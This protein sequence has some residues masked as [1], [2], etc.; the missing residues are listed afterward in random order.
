MTSDTADTVQN[1]I[2]PASESEITADSGIRTRRDLILWLALLPVILGL[3]VLC[4][5]VAMLFN[6]GQSPANTQSL[7]RAS[8]TAWVYDLIP[9]INIPQLIED[10]QDDLRAE[11]IV[12]G[13]LPVVT[14]SFWVPP[15]PT[16]TATPPGGIST[17]TL[18]PLADTATAT[19]EAINT[20]APIST[21][22]LIPS[23]TNT[24]TPTPTITNTWAPLFT[25]TDEPREPTSTR[26]PTQTNTAIPTR[27]PPTSTATLKPPPTLTSTATKPPATPIPPTAVP[28]PVYQHISPLVAKNG[29]NPDGEG[30]KAYFE[31]KNDNAY[32]VTIQPH[33]SLNQLNFENFA[34]LPG[35]FAPGRDRA[36]EIVWTDGGPVIWELDGGRAVADWC[37]P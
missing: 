6:L 14:G 37:N 22:T 31:Y 7:L 30:C 13:P 1:E 24:A 18:A 9:P 8:Y 36:F 32:V 25:A 26:A 27:R 5:Q 20:R 11:G 28:P 2:P 33:S 19:K 17:A 4:G 21:A 10:I 34:D 3:L 35:T 12:D 23:A 16:E 15:T 29:P